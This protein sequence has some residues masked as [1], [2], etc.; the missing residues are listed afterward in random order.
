MYRIGY[1]RNPCPMPVPSGQKGSISESPTI[2]KISSNLG[3]ISNEDKD[4][5]V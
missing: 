3:N 5:N 1:L 2:A 4:I